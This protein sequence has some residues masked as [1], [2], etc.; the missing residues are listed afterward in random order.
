MPFK[1]GHPGYNPKRGKNKKCACGK[2]FYAYP[3]LEKVSKYCSQAC[4]RKYRKYGQLL[5]KKNPK[6]SIGKM[7]NKNPMFGKTK[8]KPSVG[9]LH[10]YV[11][12]Y[13]PKV[14]KCEKCGEKRKLEL[15]NLKNHK[16]TRNFDD[17]A[18]MCKDCHVKFDDRLKHLELGRLGNNFKKI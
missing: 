7:G 2:E 15:A 13:K 10:D 17:Y 18:W 4:Q 14:E 8:D 11:R 12:K 3:H 16:Y 1:K 6:G 5:G 9:A